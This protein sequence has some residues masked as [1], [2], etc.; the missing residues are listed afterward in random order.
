MG[1]SFSSG[2]GTGDY[3]PA[4]KTHAQLCHRS[5]KQYATGVM[6]GATNPTVI[7]IACSG[8]VMSVLSS[9]KPGGQSEWNTSNG[10][11]Q[12]LNDTQAPSS[13]FMT[14]GGND[15]GFAKL[16]ETCLI[17][18]NCQR[19]EDIKA[20][21]AN[22]L[23]ALDGL[24]RY[25]NNVFRVANT[26][27]KRSARD[28]AIAPVIVLAYP[29][30]VPPTDRANCD[31][32]GLTRQEVDFLNNTLNGLN[33]KIRTEV[34]QAWANGS[35]VYFVDDTSKSM[36]P[37]HHMCDAKPYAVPASAIAGIPRRLFDLSLNNPAY[38]TAV[39]S[40]R[41]QELAHPNIEGHNAMAASIHTWSTK[42][43]LKERPVYSDVPEAEIDLKGGTQR[44]DDRTDIEANKLSDAVI[45][46][47]DNIV[48]TELERKFRPLLWVQTLMQ[49]EPR[50]LANT[51]ADENGVV[52]P[53]FTIPADTPPGI[54]HLTF[55]GTDAQGNYHQ[56]VYEIRVKQRIPWWYWGFAAVT[57]L[58]ALGA[59][60]A[61]WQARRL[62]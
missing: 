18:A 26:D 14:L 1:D 27:G 17:E 47:G 22:G 57:G 55:S 24:N 40:G 36:A 13:V 46:A 59:L 48:V 43:G 44:P 45:E 52:V 15:I 23:V 62:R 10:Q 4:N 3:L 42:V 34:A 51:R 50:I 6:K 41:L 37:D 29:D 20:N 7:N 5:D 9:P 32:L 60:A 2:E 31:A 49:S 54:H 61:L 30:I 53:T 28:G 8:A 11:I 21:V 39:V 35:E 58:S 16:A 33:F 25:Y 19:N 56:E 38:Q 12:I